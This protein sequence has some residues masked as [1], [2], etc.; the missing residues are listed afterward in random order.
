MGTAHAHAAFDAG[1]P[2]GD[3][4]VHVALSGAPLVV[5]MTPMDL[6]VRGDATAVQLRLVGP[7]GAAGAWFVPTGSVAFPSPGDWTIEA[8]SGTDVARFD[9][10]VW[11]AGPF[12]APRGEAAARGVV[13]AGDASLAYALTDAS[14]VPRAWPEDVVVRMDG[15]PVPATVTG[16]QLVVAAAWAAGEH[17]L[18]F[19]SA[20]AGLA[21]DARPPARVLAVPPE[22]AHV[23]GLGPADEGGFGPGVLAA[24][25]A[26][27][28]LLAG[29]GLA[30][31][32]A[33][34]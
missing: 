1:A 11:P 24:G 4:S 21:E 8:R 12:V 13:V 27:L 22:E 31:R 18:T 19:S 3:R 14:G 26:A 20:S 10:D 32:R 29:I 34:G 9:V 15:E 17:A 6:V 7:A 16:D 25:A 2:L 30:A 23:Y 33:R 28:A 5:A